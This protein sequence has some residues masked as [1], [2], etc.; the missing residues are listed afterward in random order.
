MELPHGDV[1][2]VKDTTTESELMSALSQQPVSIAI[3]ADLSFFQLHKTGV[4]K[5]TRGQVLSKWYQTGVQQPVSIV[6]DADQCFLQFCKTGA[7]KATS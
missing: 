5:A 6:I 4:R 2:G 3:E 7:I 1:V